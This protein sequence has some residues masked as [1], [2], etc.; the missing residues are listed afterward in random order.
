MGALIEQ[1]MWWAKRVALVALVL[2]AALFYARWQAEASAH[3]ATRAQAAAAALKSAQD[4]QKTTDQ[5]QRD[6][7][8]AIAKAT[9]SAQRN[10][11]D[12]DSA[13]TELDRLRG[14]IASSPGAGANTGAASAHGASALQELFG[15]CAGALA[16]LAATAD[17]L[18]TDRLTL[19]DAW[20]RPGPAP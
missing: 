7:D 6:K 17:R 2:C 19:L 4:A 11:A 9:I 12:A 20:P 18:N 13:R 5:L 1:A 14:A 15:Q 8:H 16:G 10:R 3:A